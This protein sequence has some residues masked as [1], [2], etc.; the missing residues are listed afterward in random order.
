MLAIFIG[1]EGETLQPAHREDL[2]LLE[3]LFHSHQWLASP[4][5]HGWPRGDDFS[6]A[7]CGTAH[8]APASL[9]QAPNALVFSIGMY[10]GKL[11]RRA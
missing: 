10:L 6:G 7:S 4:C 8:A 5:Q 9:S 3:T 1:V 11:Y 2:L